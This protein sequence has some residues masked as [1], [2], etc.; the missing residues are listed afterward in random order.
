MLEEERL[1]K[2]YSCHMPL[3]QERIVDG[4]LI[5]MIHPESAMT[6]FYLSNDSKMDVRIC[7]SCKKLDLTN[8]DVQNNIMSNIIDGWQKEQN[9]LLSRGQITQEQSEAIMNGHRDIKIIFNSEG[10]NDY[11]I[12]ARSS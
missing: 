10:M 8:S 7:L 11:Q 1:I 5:K 3:L 4:K 6:Q 9:I 2:C 12:K